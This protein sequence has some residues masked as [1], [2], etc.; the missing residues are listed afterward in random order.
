M[1][2]A[3]PLTQWWIGLISVI[4]GTIIPVLWWERGRWPLGLFVSPRLA[5]PE[6]LAGSVLGAA[7]VGFCALTV[8]LSTGVRHAD[9]AGFPWLELMAVFLPAAV[10]EELLFRGYGF[11]KLF[12]WNRN[13]ALLTGALLFTALHFGNPSVS[14]IGLANIFLG[15]ILLGLAYARHLRLWFP[16]GLHLAWILMTGPILGHEVSGYGSISTVL[17]EV[18]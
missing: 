3:F 9:G 13:F 5:V 18:G 1:W 15:G 12:V 6:F 16:I 7:L 11:Q 10:H 17:I 14:L 4:V 2:L 8:V